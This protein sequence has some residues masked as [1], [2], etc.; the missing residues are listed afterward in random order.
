M[1]K[2]TESLEGRAVR[3]EQARAGTGQ[4]GSSCHTQGP[5]SHS[6]DRHTC[7]CF[8]SLS[9]CPPPRP[10]ISH[11]ITLNPN[12]L[13][14]EGRGQRGSFRRSLTWGFSD[15]TSDVA[16]CLG[17]TGQSPRT[18]SPV[19]PCGDVAAVLAASCS[20]PLVSAGRGWVSFSGKQLQ[21]G[22]CVGE[23]KMVPVALA[24]GTP[25]DPVASSKEGLSLSRPTTTGRNRGHRLGD[26][27][28]VHVCKPCVEDTELTC[29]AT[30]PG[31]GRPAQ[32]GRRAGPDCREGAGAAGPL[33]QRLAL[34]S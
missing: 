20:C 30:S 19:F 26:T 17:P 32:G 6:L 34:C 4:A 29:W 8:N 18:S 33:P 3:D 13:R 22:A 27:C 28:L 14:K 23:D 1:N 31:E 25:P 12:W 15:V 7:H 16:S 24:H 11:D 10:R 2:P 9:Y 5:I 21:S